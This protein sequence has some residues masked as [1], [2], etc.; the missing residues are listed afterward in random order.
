M[1]K[2]IL[3]KSFLSL[4]HHEKKTK[5]APHLVLSFCQGRKITHKAVCFFSTLIFVCFPDE[6]SIILRQNRFC[7]NSA[8][9][10]LHQIIIVLFQSCRDYLSHQGANAETVWK[11]LISR[12]HP[13][14]F[15]PIT[16]YTLYTHYACCPKVTS[17]VVCVFP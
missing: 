1:K 17:S 5:S 7:T 3:T 13:V 8:S 14:N 2:T 12:V 9:L 4:F 10:F 6:C 11:N 15:L 16:S